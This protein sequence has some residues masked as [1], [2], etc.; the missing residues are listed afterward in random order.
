RE[1]ALRIARAGEEDAA[2]RTALHQ[3]TLVAFLAFHASRLRRCALAAANLADG[4]AVGIAGAGEERTVTAG[5]EHHL[6]AAVLAGRLR[7]GGDVGLQQARVLRV[8]AIGIAG[9]GV[10]L[11]EARALQLHRLAAFV[12]DDRLALGLFGDVAARGLLRVLA[13]R[14]IRAG[15]ELAEAAELDRHR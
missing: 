10:E 12:A 14:I 6:L 7:L 9:A 15:Q 3:L 5:L 2:P 13:L 8:L 4:L 11:A 1:V